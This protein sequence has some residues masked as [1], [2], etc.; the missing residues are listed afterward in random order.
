MT[1][2]EPLTI[3]DILY[4]VQQA[5]WI[6]LGVSVVLIAVSVTV[7]VRSGRERRPVEKVPSSDEHPL[8]VPFARG[9]A[10]VGDQ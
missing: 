5:G 9:V 6:G 7:I 10:R 1:A 2:S 4:A 8:G 3:L